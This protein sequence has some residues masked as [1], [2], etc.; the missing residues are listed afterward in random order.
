MFRRAKIRVRCTT[1]QNRKWR[2]IYCIKIYFWFCLASTFS[3]VG[4]AN[5]YRLDDRGIGVAFAGGYL[6]GGKPTRQWSWPV[7]SNDAT[8]KKTWIFTSI[9]PYAFM[10]KCVRSSAQGEL[11]LCSTHTLCRVD[12]PQA[13]GKAMHV[14]GG[15]TLLLFARS[16]NTKT[17]IIVVQQARHFPEF[18][19]TWWWPCRPKHVVQW[20]VLKGFNFKL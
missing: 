3:T 13:N 2:I 7:N 19:S 1:C 8:V 20:R 4:L 11:Y 10:A 18:L 17:L 6:P 12:R 14:T 5:G 9:P 15:T 16:M